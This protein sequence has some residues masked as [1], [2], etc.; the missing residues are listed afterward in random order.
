MHDHYGF[1]QKAVRATER[2]FLLL[3][4]IGSAAAYY[5]AERSSP[6]KLGS[7]TSRGRFSRRASAVRCESYVNVSDLRCE[8]DE[9]VTLVLVGAG[10]AGEARAARRRVLPAG[11]TQLHFTYAPHAH[12]H[13]RTTAATTQHKL[14]RSN[15]MAV[16]PNYIFFI[17]FKQH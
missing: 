5:S 3:F 9:Y 12:T 7:S 16:M 14:Y 17:I 13:T 8:Y 4:Y 2:K 1:W 6:I 15:H 11:C 10:G